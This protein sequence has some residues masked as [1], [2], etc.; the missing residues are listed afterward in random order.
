MRGKKRQKDLNVCV[1]QTSYSGL[2]LHVCAPGSQR[3]DVAHSNVAM[4][5]T[6]PRAETKPQVS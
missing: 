6:C 3:A 4:L 1:K 5:A 2:D